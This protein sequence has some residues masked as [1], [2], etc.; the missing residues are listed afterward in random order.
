MTLEELTRR[1]E[2]LQRERGI[3]LREYAQRIQELQ[4]LRNKVEQEY[5]QELDRLQTL[6]L[7]QIGDKEKVETESFVLTKKRPNLS[8]PANYKL[9]LPKDKEQKEPFIQYLRQEHSGLIKETTEYKPIQND[10][11]KLIADG[12]F[13]LTEDYQ[14]IDDNGCLIPNL[15]VD[16]KGVEVKVKVKK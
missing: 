10:F 16:V 1:Y 9:Q 13:H 5:Q 11:K 15:K 8:R 2:E 14:V 3:K 4:W 12:V 6:I 7:K